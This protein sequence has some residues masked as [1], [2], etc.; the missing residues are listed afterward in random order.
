MPRRPYSFDSVSVLRE[1]GEN[2]EAFYQKRG[3]VDMPHRYMEDL[4]DEFHQA[5]APFD[6]H[7]KR[8]LNEYGPRLAIMLSVGRNDTNKRIRVSSEHLERAEVLIRWFYKQ[9]STALQFVET[10]QDAV[11]REDYISR[12]TTII[13]NHQPCTKHTI[14]AYFRVVGMMKEERQRIVEEVI[15]RGIVKYEN[16]L[17]KVI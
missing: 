2:V 4:Y 16:K 15:D 14:S 9:G 10:N 3:I 1:I 11:E 7:W 8:L 5:T 12:L 13:K 17:Y 6:S